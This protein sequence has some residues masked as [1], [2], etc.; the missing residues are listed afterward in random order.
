MI[1]KTLLSI[2]FIL[3]LVSTGYCASGQVTCGSSSAVV[4]NSGSG[5]YSVLV[6]QNQTPSVGVYIDRASNV[7]SSTGG[8]Y[9]STNTGAIF[10]TNSEAGNW[11]CI[12]ASG[13]ATVGYTIKR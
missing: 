6:I 11:Y 10:T 12:T 9:L 2:I 8:L 13:T 5:F 1:K 4:I 3:L 7:T